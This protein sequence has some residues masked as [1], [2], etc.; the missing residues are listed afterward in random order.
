MYTSK[1]NNRFQTSV[2]ENFKNFDSSKDNNYFKVCLE[3]AC[4]L[5]MALSFLM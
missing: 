1:I 4:L 2:I 3:K 5:K